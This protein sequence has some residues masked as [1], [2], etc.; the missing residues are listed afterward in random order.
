VSKNWRPIAQGAV[1]VV[2][3]VGAGLC[4]AVTDGVCAAAFPLIFAAAGA[5]NYAIS[6]GGHTAGG[7]AKAIA[8][9]GI[10][11]GG[12]MVCA[13]VCPELTAATILVGGTV[14]LAGAAVGGID[15]LTSP[16]PKSWGKL[17][18]EM[19]LG[20]VENGPFPVDKMLKV[21]GIGK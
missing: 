18:E 2:A 3:T 10:L 21:F 9:G 17:G 4:F 11:G 6:G 5:A 8:E 1:D 7:Y 19:A 16:G 12:A 20:A 14:T 15:Y 13:L